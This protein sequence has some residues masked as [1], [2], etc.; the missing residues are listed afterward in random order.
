ML[1]VVFKSNKADG[2][3][4]TMQVTEGETLAINDSNFVNNS[5]SLSGG[6]VSS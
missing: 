5:A 3:G 4:G 1:A 2:N 6:V